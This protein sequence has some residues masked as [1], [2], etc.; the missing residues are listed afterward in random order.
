MKTITYD[1]S[2]WKLVPVEPTEEMLRAGVD[3]A[4]AQKN[5][6]PW[7]PPCYRAMLAAAPSAP[8][9]VQG[10]ADRLDAERYRWLTDGKRGD[11]CWNNVLSEEDRSNH[12]YLEEAIDAARK[13]GGKV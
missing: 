9:T 4:I 8:A 6:R 3:A 13:E 12:D 10:D 5:S 1:E 2:K 11:Y 7:C